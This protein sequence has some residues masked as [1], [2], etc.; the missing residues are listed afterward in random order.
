MRDVFVNDKP[1]KVELL[2]NMNELELG[3]VKFEVEAPAVLLASVPGPINDQVVE[4]LMV[5]L[6]DVRSSGG[7]P[8]LWK[9]S[10]ITAACTHFYFT[11][12]Q[13]IEVR[14][15]TEQIVSY[16]VHS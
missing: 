7:G 2:A 16:S 3:T 9:L 6:G 5:A 14:H 1:S 13:A 10:I 15:V 8:P 11:S 12:K 4:W